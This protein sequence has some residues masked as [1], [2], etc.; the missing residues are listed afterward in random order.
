[1][2]GGTGTGID[3]IKMR[4]QSKLRVK[5]QGRENG[6][7]TTIRFEGVKKGSR[8]VVEYLIITSAGR[9]TLYFGKADFFDQWREKIK[10]RLN[11]RGYYVCGLNVLRTTP[12]RLS[13]FSNYL[14]RESGYSNNYGMAKISLPLD[15]KTQGILEKIV[16]DIKKP[17][18]K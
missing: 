7:Q 1:M 2:G 10:N 17:T 5:R 11:S 4:I 9:K 18:S 6:M 8:I 15:S 14:S 13:I 16:Q 12:P 3:L